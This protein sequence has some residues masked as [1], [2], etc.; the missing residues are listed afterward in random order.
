MLASYITSRGRLQLIDMLEK[1]N[2]IPGVLP[3]YSDTDSVYYSIDV[4]NFNRGTFN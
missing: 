1:L 4:N 3:V 2:T